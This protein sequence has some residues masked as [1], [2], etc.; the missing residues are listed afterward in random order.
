MSTG[1]KIIP[2]LNK[3]TNRRKLPFNVSWEGKG[4]EGR[5]R[6]G[7]GRVGKGREGVQTGENCR[8]MFR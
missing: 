7:K 4:R 6:E 8:L 1:E 3:S 2:Q 5:G